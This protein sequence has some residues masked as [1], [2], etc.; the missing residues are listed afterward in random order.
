MTALATSTKGIDLAQAIEQGRRD[1]FR[2]ILADLIECR[3]SKASVKKAANKNPASFYKSLKTVSELAGYESGSHEVTNNILVQMNGM[4]DSALQA[5]LQAI[6]ADNTIN[7][8]QD[9]LAE[10]RQ[11]TSPCK[12]LMC[13]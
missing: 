12:A 5:E 2:E 3:P 13:I 4:S 7:P 9:Q 8:I 6:L 11:P 10:E 1:H